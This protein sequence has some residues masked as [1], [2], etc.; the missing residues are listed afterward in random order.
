MDSREYYVEMWTHCPGGSPQ[1]DFAAGPFDRE[2][3]L[4]VADDWNLT[5]S[6]FTNAGVVEDPFDEEDA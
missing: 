3:A 5:S 2:E 4:N 6:W 1:L